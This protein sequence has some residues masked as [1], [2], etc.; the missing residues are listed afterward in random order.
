M[1]KIL[2]TLAISAF[3]ATC[4]TGC[5]GE[6]SAPKQEKKTGSTPTNKVDDK[7][8]SDSKPAGKEGTKSENKEVKSSAPL[9]FEWNHWRGPTQNGVSTDKNL[10]EKWSP[11]PETPDNNLI[12]KTPF[13][14]RTTPIVQND[15]V[16]IINKVGKGISEQER[17]M[18]FSM[19]DGKLLWEHKFNVFHTDIVSVRLGWTNMA[20]DPETGNVYAHGTQG[21][22]FCF[23]K[24]GK[25]LW[26]KSLT[27]EYGRITG[28]GGR[29]TSPIVD[30][31]LLIIGM[32]NASWG[33]QGMGRNR[34]VAFNKKTGV[35]QWWSSTGAP[36]KDTYYSYPVV[37]N[38]NGQGMVGFM[39][40]KLTLAKKF[41]VTFSV[42]DPLTVPLSFKTTL[43]T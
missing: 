36:V 43:S 19:K 29:V 37:A 40:L 27:E 26:S 41:G 25:V 35:I 20:G 6:T 8:S 39:L 21:L 28:Y 2:H 24:D 5:G 42:A 12:W 13:G 3:F 15:R 7:K 16:Y 33:D 30:G 4:F 34:F 32:I 11:N 17:V 38:I 18:C 1:N 9:A 23:D 31:D 10:P 14:G 22:L